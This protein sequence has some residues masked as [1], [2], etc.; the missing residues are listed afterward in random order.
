MVVP[1]K[2]GLAPAASGLA[3]VA[4][5]AAAIPPWRQAVTFPRP[6]PKPVLRKATGKPGHPSA[7]KA[8]VFPPDDHSDDLSSYSD[9]D[10]SSILNDEVWPTEELAYE[11]GNT[12]LVALAY[13]TG[14]TSLLAYKQEMMF[15][16][17]M[18]KRWKRNILQRRTYRT[19]MIGHMFRWKL[20]PD[21][22]KRV[23]DFL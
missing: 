20:S 10:M 22:C 18:L 17:M 3:P 12:S 15:Q 9:S 6:A 8:A 1:P 21:L 2:P 23:S 14:N 4:K 5:V 19:R 16:R 13:E 7:A 11:T